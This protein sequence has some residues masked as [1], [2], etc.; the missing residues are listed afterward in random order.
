MFAGGAGRQQLVQ[1]V[2]QHQQGDPRLQRVSAHPQGS[3]LNWETSPRPTGG[4]QSGEFS[5]WLKHEILSSKWLITAL[6]I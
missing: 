1:G 4:V 6:W 3:C 5:F 2:L